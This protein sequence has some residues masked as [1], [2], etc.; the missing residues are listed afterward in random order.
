MTTIAEDLD[1]T[2]AAI[3]A[4][5]AEALERLVRDAM[6]LVD[7]RPSSDG[8][9]CTVAEHF[10]KFAG[11]LEGDDWEPPEDPPPEASIRW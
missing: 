9:H 8:G 11:V 1:K 6:A 3:D 10:K 4:E 5:S 7:R 2:L